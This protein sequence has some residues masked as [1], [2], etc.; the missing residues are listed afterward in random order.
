MRSS[1][2][3]QGPDESSPFPDQPAN[4][5]PSKAETGHE[6]AHVAHPERMTVVAATNAYLSKYEN[7]EIRLS[8][9][10]KYKTMTN[11]LV[12]FC[13]LKGYIYPDQLR[14]VGMDEIY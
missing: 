1:A 6:A 7:R 12:P 4:L 10:G 14:V 9:L 2:L 13:A 3:A 5:E 8:S 11:Q